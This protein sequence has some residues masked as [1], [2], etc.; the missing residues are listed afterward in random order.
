MNWIFLFF[1]IPHILWSDSA[2]PQ[3]GGKVFL[4]LS[5]IFFESPLIYS[6]LIFLSILSLTIWLYTTFT[7]RYREIVPEEFLEKIEKYSRKSMVKQIEKLCQEEDHL[8]ARMVSKGM[9]RRHRGS[10]VM[11][12]S[13]E[14]EGRRFIQLLSHRID[15]LQD[16]SATAPMLGLLGTVWGLFYAF[17][18]TSRSIESLL[19]IFDGLG[20]AMGTTVCGLIVSILST[21]FYTLLKQRLMAIFSRVE[22]EIEQLSFFLAPLSE[23]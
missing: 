2:L 6:I 8:L 23:K 13:M 7:T 16:I 9:K 3:K 14:N 18:D 21:S 15:F 19:V 1:S 10:K 11:H 5:K 17:Y 20:I 12:E 22:N 4:D